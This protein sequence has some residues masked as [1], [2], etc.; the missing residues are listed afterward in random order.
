L[1]APRLLGQ[2]IS[3]L[4]KQIAQERLAVFHKS[5]IDASASSMASWLVYKIANLPRVTV[6]VIVTAELSS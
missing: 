2:S 1:L 5:S 4:W 3:H 6:L